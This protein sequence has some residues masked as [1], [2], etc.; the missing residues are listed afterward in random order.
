MWWI[1]LVARSM[2]DDIAWWM[3]PKTL[4]IMNVTKMGVCVLLCLIHTPLCTPTSMMHCLKSTP[5]CLMHYSK[6]LIVSLWQIPVHTKWFTEIN[7]PRWTM[8]GSYP[9][10][11]ML[12]SSVMLNSQFVGV[13]A[14]PQWHCI[15]PLKY[16]R[17]LLDLFT[18]WFPSTDRE[19]PDGNLTRTCKV[20][21]TF[22][23][24]DIDSS[25]TPNIIEE[26]NVGEEL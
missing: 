8:K 20:D 21:F 26:E 15:I 6:T 25:T 16:Y 1:V 4:L 3:T 5:S 23:S 12:L 11:W 7:N 19:T 18:P 22:L 9:V 17:Q 2:M 24:D 10:T 13:C 14:G